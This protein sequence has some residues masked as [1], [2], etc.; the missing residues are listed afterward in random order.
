MYTCI[1]V[2]V[3]GNCRE[4]IL[5]RTVS[6]IKDRYKLLKKDML[7]LI[8]ISLIRSIIWDSNLNRKF[9]S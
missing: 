9:S 5:R 4:K 7:L 3:F 2:T 1:L 8:Y 6:I